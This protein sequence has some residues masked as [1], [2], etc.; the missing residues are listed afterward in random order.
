MKIVTFLRQNGDLP[1][2]VVDFLRERDTFRNKIVDIVEEFGQNK[3]TTTTGK[4]WKSSR[5]LRVKPNF[6]IFSLFIIFLHFSFFFLFSGLLQFRIFFGLNCFKI[7]CNIFFSKKK[8]FF[9]PSRGKEYHFGPSFLF[10][11]CQIFFKKKVPSFLFSCISC[12]YVL[13]LGIGIRV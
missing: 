11:P 13:L 5:I 3:V 2:L 8:H 4:P 6:F 10:F 7:S 1:N 12:K 9:E